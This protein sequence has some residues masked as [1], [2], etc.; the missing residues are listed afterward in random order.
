MKI[1]DS[2]ADTFSTA[3]TGIITGL[4][5]AP[6]GYQTLASAN[7]LDGAKLV[8]RAETKNKSVWEVFETIYTI[9]TKQFSRGATLRSSTNS[10][11]SFPAGTKNIYI[12]CASEEL[13]QGVLTTTGDL[14]SLDS[15]GKLV[16]IPTGTVGY[17]LTAN[18]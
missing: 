16:R 12:V 3:G 1:F 13:A 9:S 18:G 10:Q 8:V 2:T 7:V 15:N 17:V 5:I 11:I 14:L 4:G 6:T